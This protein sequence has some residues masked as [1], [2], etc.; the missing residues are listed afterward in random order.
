MASASR[1]LVALVMSGLQGAKKLPDFFWGHLEKDVQLLARA[2]GKNQE[3][4]A[5]VVHL[6]LQNMVTSKSEQGEI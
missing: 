5:T 2:I 4:A 6:V 1:D 3:D